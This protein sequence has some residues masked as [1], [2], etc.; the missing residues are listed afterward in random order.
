MKADYPFFKNVKS[1]FPLLDLL[2]NENSGPFSW[3][4]LY[5]QFDVKI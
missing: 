2:Q 5:V 3:V 1:V 4:S